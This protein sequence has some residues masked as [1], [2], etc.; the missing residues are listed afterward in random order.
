[1]TKGK[2]RKH[3][4]SKNNFWAVLGPGLLYAGAAVGV[5]HL[6]QST[7]AGAMFGFDLIWILVI[8]N[9]LKYPFFDYGARFA[10][11][12]GKNLI[13]GYA[14]IGKWAVVLFAILSFFS[15]FIIQAAVTVV[16]VGLFAYIFK[17]TISVTLLSALI[18][19]VSVIIL[20]F[21]KYSF[22]DK[23]M[24]F[25]IVLL[26][27]STIVAVFSALGID[28]Q[29]DPDSLK[30]FSWTTKADILFLIAFVGW[31]PAPI[32]VSVWSSIWSVEKNKELGYKIPLHDSLFEFRVGYIGTALLAI[33][34]VSLGALVMYGT[35]EQLSANGTVFAG[36]LI[37]MYSTSIGKWSFW[38][39]SIAA[40]TTMFSTTITVLDAYSRVIPFT[41]KNISNKTKKLPGLWLWLFL[42]LT[43]TLIIIIFFATSMRVMV[44]IATTLS[45]VTAPILAYLNYK[46]VTSDIMPYYAKPQLWLRVL[47][48]VGITFFVIFSIIYIYWKVFV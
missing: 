2:R 37:K 41:I 8:A 26:A 13:D 29:I 21:G 5:S 16:T 30:N 34:F 1:M 31:M 23:L 10:T 32:D 45:F 48:W 24:K 33:G 43:G 15:M 39:I 47:S 4:K 36:Q 17:I 7:R 35:G 40:F 46:V 42:M 28:K 9:V 12:T 6:V 14:H 38:I 19:I 25:I 27:V 11:A 18:M 20:L 3:D 22:L 44:D